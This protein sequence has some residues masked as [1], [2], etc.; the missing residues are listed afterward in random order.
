M[1]EGNHLISMS[2]EHEDLVVLTTD[3]DLH[4][5]EE[6]QLAATTLV[7]STYNSSHLAD[8]ISS[9]YLCNAEHDLEKVVDKSSI[10]NSWNVGM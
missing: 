6:T 3:R 9:L 10:Y 8:C 7:C 1:L 4:Y 5:C 2:T